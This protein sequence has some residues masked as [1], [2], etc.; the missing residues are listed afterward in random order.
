MLSLPKVT[1]R[2]L[3][4]LAMATV[5]TACGG[6]NND[7]AQGGELANP[8]PVTTGDWQLEWEDTFEGSELDTASW[9]I[10]M[11]NG[12]AEGIP[13][14]GNNELQYYQPDNIIVADGV[15][16]IEARAEDVSGFNYSSGRIR[17][18]GK[19]D[20]TFGRV[21]A[22]IKLPSG[23]GL[24]S[25][26][27]LL[28]SDP[29]VYGPWAAKGEIDIVEKYQPGFSSSAIHYGSYFPQN[30][31][32]TGTYEEEVADG[33][34]HVFAVEWDADTIRFFVDG[35]NFYTINSDTYYN[36][37]YKNRNEGFVLGGDSAPFDEDQHILL[38]LAVGG[39]L[40]GAP[41]D[42]TV[43][44][45]QMQVDY[46]RVYS[47]P[48]PSETGVGCKNSIDEA[49]EYIN[50]D[51]APDA[52]VL[53]SEVI[54][55]NGV[56]TLFPGT[57]VERELELA[58]FDNNGAFSA[59]EAADENGNTVIAVTTSGGG[60]V[61]LTDASGGTFNLVNMGT[62]EF[63][64]GSADFKFDIKVDSAATDSAG[65]LQVKFDSGFPDVALATLNMADIAVDEWVQISVPVSEILSGGQGLYGGGPADIANL[66]N[67]ITFEPTGSA[68]LMLSNIRLECGAKTF[69]GIEAVAVNPL[70]IF[71]DE[72]GADWDKGIVGFDTA[73]GGDYTES[74]GNHVSWELI[75]TGDA[76]KGT[77]IQTTFDDSGASGVTYVGSTAGVDFTPWS[78]GELALD[79]KVISNPNAFPFIL[80]VDGTNQAENSTGE[81]SLGEL[82]VGEWVTIT[83]P[84]SQMIDKGLAI[85]DVGAI[86]LFPTFAGQDVV[87]QWGNIRLEPTVSE[88]PF[89]VTV[90]I[91]FEAKPSNYTFFSFEGGAVGIVPNPDMAIL[92]GSDNVAQ[93]KKFAGA[94]FAG[95]GL[96]LDKPVDFADGEVFKMAVWSSR[97]AELTFK[98][99]G[100]NIEEK[101]ALSGEGWEIVEA[102]FTGRTGA[103]DV[104]A[105]TFIFDNG[106]AGDAEGAP[107]DWTFYVDNIEQQKGLTIPG[108]I[109][110]SD[111]EDANPALGTVG[112]GWTVYA[113]VFNAD[114]GYLYGYGPFDA[115][116]GTNAFSG[117]ASSEGGANQGQN[118]LS[119]FS[120]YNNT[121]A[122]DAGDIIE[123]STFLEYTLQA[124]DTGTVVFS[125]DAKAPTDGGIQA[126][127][128]AFAYVQVLDP[129]NGFQ[130]T[131][132]QALD[133]SNVPSDQWG[134]FEIELEIDG[135]VLVGQIL[136]YG[137]TSKATAYAPSAVLYDNI[138][139]RIVKDEDPE[140]PPAEAS[141]VF[142]DD[143]EAA[144]TSG[145][146]PGWRANVNLFTPTGDY[147]DGYG[148][149]AS[150]GGPQVSAITNTE[151]GA[152]Q[153]AQSL[154]V[155]SNYD[156]G[157]HGSG[158]TLD[159]AVF[160]E[161]TI[162]DTDS[163]TYRFKFDVKRPA[164]NAVAAPSTAAGFVK[165]LD[166]SSGYATVF[167]ADVDTTDVSSSEWQT[168]SID[169]TI[170]GTAQA[171][172]L[173]QFGFS[174]QA[175]NYDPTGVLY[176]NVSVAEFEP[177]AVIS[178]VFADDFEAAPITGALPGWRA[179]VNLFTPTGDY[180]DGYG[181][182][183]SAGGPQV[184]AITNTEQ[185]A[186]Q[187]AQS[188]N[189][190][191]NYDD[192][193]H[194]SGNTLDT[195]VFREFTIAA[196]DSGSYRFQ[197]DVKRPSANAVA[198]PS[199]A[200]GFVKILDPN[201]GYATVFFDDVDTTDVSASEWTTLSIDI[202]IDG[203]AQEGM[204]IQFGFSNQA[205][206]YDPTGVLY[207][208]VSVAEFEPPAAATFAF[209]D[210]FEAAPT[211]GALPGWRANVNL[212]TPTGDYIDGYG[213][214]ASAGGPQVS[215][216]TNTEQG[217]EQGAQ[218]LNVY[219]NYDDGNHGSG[220]TLDTAVFRE[221]TIAAGDS[222][223]YRF[224]FD[225][226]RPSANAVAAPSTAAG[227]VKILDPNSGYAT[228]FFDDVD[229]TDVSAS[230]WTT[231]S[232]D[233]TIDGAAQEGMLIQF[234]FSNQATN[235]DPTG[236]LYDNVTV[237]GI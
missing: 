212:F 171:G 95:S 236:V 86:V 215:A 19:V 217:A 175:T 124:T 32:A 143:F 190:Y 170:D 107:D 172:M 94:T 195:A 31:V 85:T 149:A 227:F 37:Y 136:Q 178:F 226:K 65:T 140:E 179:N 142:V 228:V 199:T 27:W 30:E 68:S 128:E 77:V 151:Q 91:D 120:D 162:A 47:C 63:P 189:V 53:S 166:P 5:L 163:G 123:A 122:Q 125:F 7:A 202:T 58:V 98:L 24:W 83:L 78:G 220:N 48:V 224:Q 223:S 36:Y 181:F 182:A 39:N 49:D 192:G 137:F 9:D 102:D 185:G 198:A 64:L 200:A 148:F 184:S 3:G 112:G 211:S 18:Q 79:V 25:A 40:P 225:V 161:F 71:D 177:P 22:S 55:N 26:F 80:K 115:P 209:A 21:E 106:T 13:G 174:N 117:V 92:N 105:L 232:I 11:G 59:T 154:N 187:G 113:N 234:G 15:L 144:P 41:S 135:A 42:A 237:E 60:N 119:V 51:V 109:S 110:F 118:A 186:E 76:D 196:G 70:V 130:V 75:D 43:F 97:V 72:L 103:V 194:G 204:L 93:F 108:Q 6:G 155:Y 168:L 147:I 99:E 73:V 38:N 231:L 54:Y 156:D 129:N 17:T 46:V 57:N 133:L 164:A 160:R 222:G 150:A 193:N 114:G 89:E 210:D 197:F 2:T 45:A 158:N 69:C 230:E 1:H 96:V 35:T 153:G 20:F 213:F 233:I 208:N 61:S 203:A 84:V 104:G 206:N 235:Y 66:V 169:I 221:F 33:E 201:S 229:T 8:P 205:T 12:A 145:E 87:F 50:F 88:P 28:G 167:F 111:F 157:N 132:R 165:I 188:L 126:P 56:A 191:S 100:L 216:I 10:Q 62:V 74:T 23:Q 82:P 214:A 159:T 207:D 138:D 219:S 81:I 173:I 101:L 116:S 16:T 121:G 44:P 127:S 176:D 146:L 4:I 29:S 90:P 131:T 141:F 152:E 180:I 218:S 134:S 183:A 139:L 14:W 34:F 67:L 52:P